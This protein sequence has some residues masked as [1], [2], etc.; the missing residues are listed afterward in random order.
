MPLLGLEW[1]WCP[2]HQKQL[3]RFGACVSCHKP[4]AQQLSASYV[5]RPIGSVW[6]RRPK[7]TN[8][9]STLEQQAAQLYAQG[10][11]PV[12]IGQRLGVSDSVAANALD[13]AA[14]KAGV[15]SRQELRD[16]HA[17]RMER[18][19]SDS[20]VIASRQEGEGL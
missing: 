10:L 14:V 9:L 7:Q 11:G 16:R 2:E 17:V 6:D 15:G 5:N 13:R 20:R 8:D 19:L 18:A 1:N 3:H 12:A 4:K